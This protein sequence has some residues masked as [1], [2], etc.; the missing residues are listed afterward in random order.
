MRWTPSTVLI[1]GTVQRLVIF[2]WGIY[3]D[4]HMVPRFT[5]VDYLVF[6]DAAKFVHDGSSPYDRDTYRY[7]P[8]LAWFLLPNVYWFNF[9]KLLF[10]AG[11][12]VAGYLSLQIFRL[13]GIPSREACI[14]TSL[15]LLNPMVSVISTRG[16]SEGFLGAIIIFML[17][18]T[19]AKRYWLAGLSA[20]FAVHYKIYPII[21]I[22]TIIWALGPLDI[23]SFLNKKRIQFAV[24][25]LASFSVLTGAMLAIYG[26]DYLQH[27][28][29]HHVTRLDHRHNFS[30]YSTILYYASANPDLGWHFE[31]WAFLPQ[32]FLSGVALPLAFARRDIART[33][34]IQTL[35]FVTFNK[36]CTS[37]Y[38]LWYLVLLPFA[39]PKLR[40]AGPLK[41]A[42][43]A[44][45]VASQAMW[46]QH[47]YQLEFLGEST[48]FPHLFWDTV[49]FFLVNVM[50]I[51]LMIE[52]LM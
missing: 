4:A 13:Q 47:A 3:Q 43:L 5:D 38:F 36:V 27:S 42:F 39:V 44:L 49:G 52:W 17:W 8:L 23:K 6:T 18:A 26:N 22:P 7:T 31:R 25:A 45:W 30:V 29:L 41:Y 19:Y 50:G 20:G 34:F 48:F 2:G 28:W 15:W 12:L 21:Y 24:G 51:C 10:V 11:D 16:S 33:M 35:T 46:L 32:L 40:E 14:Y 1:L 9:G 37:Q